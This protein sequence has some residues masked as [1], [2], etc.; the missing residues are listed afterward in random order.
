L[1]SILKFKIRK[2]IKKNLQ[3]SAAI[4]FNDIFAGR[5]LP[6]EL[7][8]YRRFEASKPVSFF[9]SKLFNFGA[10][11]LVSFGATNPPAHPEDWDGISSRNVGKPHPDEAVYL[12]ILH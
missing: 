2:E 11:K 1:C 10:K 3:A 7:M 4:E 6:Q 12:R 9:A 8:V 5:Q